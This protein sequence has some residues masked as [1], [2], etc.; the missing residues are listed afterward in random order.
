MGAPPGTISS[1]GWKMSRTEPSN[2]CSRQLVG[3][4]EQDRGVRV[5]PAA[6]ADTLDRRAVRHILLVVDRQRVDVGSQGDP[7]TPTRQ[8]TAG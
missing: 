8:L 4:P 1:A 7:P 6:V 2:L 3:D 5:V